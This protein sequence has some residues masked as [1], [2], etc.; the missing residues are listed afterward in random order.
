MH[1]VVEPEECDCEECAP[2]PRGPQG[3]VGPPGNT[4]GLIGPQGMQGPQNGS[5]SSIN[6]P[7]GYMGPDCM[8]DI[9]LFRGSQGNY[10]MQGFN[11]VGWQGSQG[12]QGNAIQGA[13]GPQGPQ[14]VQGY[15]GDAIQ[16]FQGFQGPDDIGPTGSQGLQGALI[17]AGAQG[18]IGPQGVFTSSYNMTT[19]GAQD[20]SGEIIA[21][22]PPPSN[23][24]KY[25]FT[26]SGMSYCTLGSNG[27]LQIKQ[28]GGSVVFQQPYQMPSSLASSDYRIP[29]AIDTICDETTPLQVQY[30]PTIGSYMGFSNYTSTFIQIQ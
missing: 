20:P 5:S 14:G 15:E 22:F 9:T 16:G 3:D 28:V 27:S 21:I 26:F 25:L 2:C 4:S 17:A 8:C 11:I 30:I 12:V 18:A 1:F 23:V 6:G 24:G 19:V 7:Q 29:L 13:Q 10:G